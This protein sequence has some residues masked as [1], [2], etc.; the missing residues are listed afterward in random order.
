MKKKSKFRL[1]FGHTYSSGNSPVCHQARY[2]HNN[3]DR[4]AT[5]IFSATEHGAHL[6]EKISGI[7]SSV[8]RIEGGNTSLSNAHATTY[9]YNSISCITSIQN[10]RTQ[11]YKK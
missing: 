8:I 10:S 3:G 5:L 4:C 7:A 11:I 9:A 6:Y 1:P 2:S